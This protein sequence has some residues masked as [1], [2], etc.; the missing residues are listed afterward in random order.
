ME[1]RQADL[2]YST[3]MAPRN[4]VTRLLDSRKVVYT[5]HELPAEKLSARQAA[6]HLG[7]RPER[8]YKTIV[9]LRP[10]RGKPLLALVNAASEVDLK[11][12]ARA[13][14]E[15]KVALATQ[16]E[17]ERITGLQ[18]GG[19]SPLAL[20]GKGFQVVIDETARHQP[21]IFIS[22]GQRSLNVE[23]SPSALQT[24]TGAILAPVSRR[25]EE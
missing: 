5:A 9:V 25:E 17:A 14:G 2:R 7:V 13:V 6:A 11:L 20:L 24:L 16:S 18:V 10:Q 4:N 15:K 12:L 8:M 22:G 1:G 23:L 21:T 3:G 19:I